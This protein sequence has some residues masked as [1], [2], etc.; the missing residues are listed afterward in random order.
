[1]MLFMVGCQEKFPTIDSSLTSPFKVVN[2]TNY[3]D[4]VFDDGYLIYVTEDLDKMAPGDSSVLVELILP[5]EYRYYIGD[6]ILAYR[7][8]LS[9]LDWINENEKNTR[10]N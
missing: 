3:I 6:T 2:F 8:E 5:E 7:L 4:T 9:Y 10:N 1:M